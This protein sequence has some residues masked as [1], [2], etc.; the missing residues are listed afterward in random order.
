M[1]GERSFFGPIKFDAFTKS[2]FC[3]LFVI[4]A[5][6]GMTGFCLFM[7]SFIFTSSQIRLDR[8]GIFVL[9]ERRP[10]LRS[11]PAIASYCGGQVALLKNYLT[12]IIQGWKTRFMK[13]RLWRD[14]ISGSVWQ[15]PRCERFGETYPPVGSQRYDNPAAS[16]PHPWPWW[17]DCRIYR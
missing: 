13:S 8:I 2:L 3:P 7:S 4:P 10:V 5:H 11:P 17:R 12:L 1:T 16:Q 6:A 9:I 15:W 14:F